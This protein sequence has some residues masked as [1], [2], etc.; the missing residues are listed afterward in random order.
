MNYDVGEGGSNK[1]GLDDESPVSPA[2]ETVFCPPNQP[3]PDGTPAGT[4]QPGLVRPPGFGAGTELLLLFVLLLLL[5][6]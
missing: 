2:V 1:G 4:E 6:S 3:G 5:N